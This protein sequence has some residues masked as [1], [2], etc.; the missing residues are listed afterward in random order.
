MRRELIAAV[1][2]A[3]GVVQGDPALPEIRRLRRIE[4]C[5]PIEP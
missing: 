5:Q 2:E 3:A 4:L 1:G